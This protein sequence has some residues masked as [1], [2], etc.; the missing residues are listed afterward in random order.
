MSIQV[1]RRDFLGLLATLPGAALL[2]WTPV[3]GAPRQVRMVFVYDPQLPG[4]VWM[5]VVLRHAP[6]SARA[7]TGDRVRFAR[8]VLASTPQ[9]IGGLTRHADRLVLTGTAEEVGFRVVEEAVLAG[10][11]KQQA[12]VFW[13]MQHRRELST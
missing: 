2:R 3:R 6:C 4:S 5:P 1:P 10:S 9:M 8:E 11:G 13:R 12:L 7:V